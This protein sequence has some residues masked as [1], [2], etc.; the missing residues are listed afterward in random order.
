MS[1]CPSSLDAMDIE[2]FVQVRQ[3]VVDALFCGSE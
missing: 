2:W 3:K 1:T